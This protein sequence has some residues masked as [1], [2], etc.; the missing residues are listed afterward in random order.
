MARVTV[1]GSSLS[2]FVEKVRRGLALKKVDYELV[3]P[4][5]PFDL[6]R[7]NPQTGKM[8]V[9][10]IDGER[11]YDSTFIL[12]RLDALFTEPTLV[13][14]DPATAAGQRLLEDGSDEALYFCVMALRWSKRNL[15]GDWMGRVGEATRTGG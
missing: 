11:T 4:K 2:P 5:S 15:L 8:P 12:R 13:S 3:P 1:Y 7:W 9:V 14:T 6:R 10:E